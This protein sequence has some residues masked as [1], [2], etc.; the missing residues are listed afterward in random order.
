MSATKLQKTATT[1]CLIIAY[2]TLWHVAA[3]FEYAPFASLWYAPAGLSVAI[4]T[5]WKNDG[6]L[7]VWLCVWFVS[8]ITQHSYYD[9]PDE[10]RVV[11]VS[12]SAAFTH[13]L[14][15]WLALKAFNRVQAALPGKSEIILLR[16]I[17]YAAL[18][19]AGSLGA[20]LLGIST[21]MTFA[22]M[23]LELAQTI[24]LAWWMGDYVGVIV[25]GPVFMILGRRYLHKI[26]EP[27]DS[28]SSHF[29]S[30]SH[31]LPKD[32]LSSIAW[33]LIILL[34]SVIA[35]GRVGF[36]DRIPIVLA[37]LL[38]LLPIAILATRSPWAVLVSATFF[39]S[40]LIIVTVKQFGVLGDA[41]T[42]Q[43]VLVATA[44]TSMFFF[45]LVRIFDSRT[46][47]LIDTSR[48][49]N[50]ANK[51]LTLNEIAA[52]IAHEISTPL[53][54]ALTSSQRVRRRLEKND[55]DWALEVNELNNIKHA[56]NQAG[57]AIKPVRNLVK[58]HQPDNYYCSIG[59][60]LLLTS[61][62]SESVAGKQ[63]VQVYFKGIP[64][65]TKVRIE[66]SELAQVLLNLV[67]NSVRSAAQTVRKQ[68][69]V[70]VHSTDDTTVSIQVTDSGAGVDASKVNDLFKLSHSTE[71][72]GLGL[73][74]SKSIAERQGGALEYI[75]KN[76]KEW[77]FKLTLARIA[78]DQ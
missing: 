74:I 11:L 29:T 59:E 12:T 24:W 10:L 64:D 55:G 78:K 72:L 23:P 42:Y 9:G 52:N 62:L 67:S 35:I 17:L 2:A 49:L 39:S 69:H 3:I 73:W 5:L 76:D 45:N 22:D 13:T 56:I 31:F 61:R 25:L 21:Q 41:I 43:A 53:Q 47:E 70:S 68:V 32:R 8:V 48:S 60:A 50:S 1:I 37:F 57:D 18:L 28:F 63:G 20:A 44:V 14:P 75:Y 6:F 33:V 19:L 71:G 54:T 58:A 34:P 30:D 15:Y 16:P 38:A 51:L 77:C 7:K 4:L 36:D 27:E 46:Q 40:V 65:K 66:Q 26:T